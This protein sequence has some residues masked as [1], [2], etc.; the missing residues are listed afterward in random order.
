MTDLDIARH[1]LVNQ[2]L[3]ATTFE[4]PE[5]VVG[6]LGAVQAQEYAGAKWAVAQRTRGLREADLE[7]AFADGSIL[8]THIMRPTWH[9]VTPADIRWMLTL[10]APRVHALNAYYYRK[11]EL[12]EAVFMRSS[13]SLEK[14]LAGGRQLL[15]SEL[16]QALQQAGIAGATDDRL[17]LAY[18]LMWA[19]LEGIVCSGAR[20]GK[21]HTY[22]LLDE[23]APQASTIERDEALGELA[24][25]YFTSHGPASLKDY[26]WWSGLPAAGARAGL[27]AIKPQLAE[28]AIDGTTY[29]FSPETPGIQKS[30]PGAHLLPAFDEY[31]VAYKDHSAIID[32][33]YSKEVIYGSVI[34]VAG[35]IAGAWKRTIGKD[36][37][38][39]AIRPFNALPE[40]AQR[41]VAAAAGC[42]GEF[43][44]KSVVV[45]FE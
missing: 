40:A 18:I 15:R 23:R 33:Q 27:E 31:T 14:A 6:W 35:Q 30:S 5:D 26:T 21:Q 9:F 16:A 11:L 13:T 10:T 2:Q 44:D 3:A 29:W 19:E 41:A 34:L 43:L 22:A 42:Y 39:I 45:E 24:R 20:R 36:R 38:Q 8:R 1:R 12:D 17:R 7:R 28:E 37:V 25:R 32:G 4:Q